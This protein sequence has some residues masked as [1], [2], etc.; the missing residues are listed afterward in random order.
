MINYSRLGYEVKRDLT[1]FCTKISHGLKRP[2]QKFIHQMIYGI[3]AGNKVHL[4]E[5]ARSLRETITLK[6]TIERLSRNLYGFDGQ[7]SLWRGYLSLVKQQVKEDYAVIVI[8]NSD[9]A[10]PAGR[11]FEALSEV[12]DGST[13][14]I[15]KGYLTIEAAVL[16]ET[17][18]MPLPIYEKVFS[19]AED[20][21]I[22]ETYENLCCLKF[23]SETFSPRCV[24]TLDRG[25][26]ANDYYRY[27]L[28]RSERFVIR[29]KKN[30]N[31][32]YHGRTCNIMEVADQYKGSYCM[33]FKN[34]KGKTF[35]CK[36]SCIPVKLCEFPGKELT[37]VAVYG[38]GAEP[39][40]L[41]SNLNMQEKKRLCHI[42]TKVYL[43]R[44]R[45]EEYFKFKKQQFELEDLR[46]MSMQSIRNLNLLATLAAGYIGLIS[47]ARSESI[48]LRELKE[49]SLRI[50][51]VP[52]FLFYALGYALERVLSMSRNGINSF[53]PKKVK[54]QQLN[55]FEYF[56][57]ADSGAFVF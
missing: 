12:R 35:H 10:K 52:R 9:I 27:F 14:E 11:K 44:W 33:D 2:Q 8:D 54:S 40:L 31:V 15:T 46:V 3:L 38:F 17:G 43:M 16:S 18:K 24:R 25:F 41:L 7:D 53:L 19:A 29:A 30:R 56:K 23:L 42:V 57:I 4:S 45:I 48:F 22:S 49:C 28:K 13:G 36:M 37:L 6:K 26:D 21:F 50:Y 51:G 34:K 20:G 47:S 1:N 32:I 39:M 5:I 55:L